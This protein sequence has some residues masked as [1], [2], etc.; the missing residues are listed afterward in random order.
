MLKKL[1]FLT[2]FGLLSFVS[3]AQRTV[4]SDSVS[5][6][7]VK[8]IVKIN[9]TSLPL[10]NVSLQYEYIVK[11]NLSLALGVRV[12]PT[13]A[14]PAEGTFLNVVAKN[15]HDAD[16]KDLVSMSRM[17]NIA[18]T[19]EVR[20]YLGRGYG[21]GLY[22]A[23]Y[24]RFNRFT[25]NTLIVNY[26]EANGPRRSVTMN[27]EMTA[28]SVGGMVGAQWFLGKNLVIDWWIAGAHF[29]VASGKFIGIPETE[30]STGEQADVRYTLNNV[31]IPF[32]SKTTTVTADEV[33]TKFNGSFG[34]LRTG[35]LLGIRF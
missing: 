18:L 5:N 12:M 20:F 14:I 2:L 16:T 6:T 27:G 7:T 35:F 21:R 26:H 4:A 29:G 11:K 28:H 13:S 1:P 32:V 17:D 15:K 10:K 23:P 30:L 19:P 9:M 8:D 31:D 3:L 34:G 24:Y 22:I 25:S 33:V